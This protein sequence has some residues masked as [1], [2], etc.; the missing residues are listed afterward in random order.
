MLYLALKAI[1]TAALV[2]AISEIAKRSPLFA[3]LVASLPLI[4]VLA[5][6]WL[7]VETGNET[8]V[9]ALCR[10]IFLMILPSLVFFLILPLALR[11]GFGFVLAMGTAIAVTAGTYW[12]YVRA[13]NKFGI[14]F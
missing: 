12:I 4:S 13:L 7:Y 6:T 14:G 2:V 10:S 11:V 3:G 1:I 5:L 9:S 8:D